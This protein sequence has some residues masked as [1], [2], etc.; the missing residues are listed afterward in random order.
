[1]Q[2]RTSYM[3]KKP[4][5]N[6]KKIART[7]T[8]PSANFWLLKYHPVGVKLVVTIDLSI[9]TVQYVMLTSWSVKSLSNIKSVSQMVR[10]IKQGIW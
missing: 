8:Y 6:P 4:Q 7:Q 1:M 3:G 5:T 9:T 2:K 10:V